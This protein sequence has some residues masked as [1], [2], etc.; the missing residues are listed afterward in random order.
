MNHIDIFQNHFKGVFPETFLVTATIIIL[1]YAVGFGVQHSMLDADLSLRRYAGT[2]MNAARL[3]VLALTLAI[4]LSAWQILP[5]AVGVIFN[6]VL[7]IDDL[8]VTVRTI[9][10][11]SA[12][13]LILISFSSIESRQ[14]INSFEYILLILFATTSMLFITSS[15]DLISMYLAIELQTL[16][17]YVLAAFRRNNAEFSTEAGLKYF[18]LGALSSGLLLFGESIIYGS[19]GITNFEELVKF[20]VLYK[21]GSASAPLGCPSELYVQTAGLNFILI[22][23]LF[24]ISAV[25]FHM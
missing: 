21:Q 12:L 20:F 16:S 6:N 9:I 13:S 14:R 25:P 19:T 23:F 1:L 3:A 7:I 10:L 11:I 18:V 15:Y 2:V 24:K 8:T 5:A 22:A 4:A 17:F